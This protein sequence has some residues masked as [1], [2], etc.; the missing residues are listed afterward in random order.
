MTYNTICNTY[1]LNTLLAAFLLPALLAAQAQQPAQI[2]LPQGGLA[3]IRFDKTT[4]YLGIPYAAPPLNQLRWRAPQAP[5]RWAGLRPAQDFG[6]ACPQEAYEG[7]SLEEMSEDC[8]TLNVWHPNS[9]LAKL[10][11]F[12][13]VHGGALVRGGA[14]VPVYDGQHLASEGAVVVTINYR[15]HH[16]GFFAHPE[17][18]AE[19]AARGESSSNFGLLD[20]Q[21]ALRWVKENASRFGGDPGRITLAGE[22][23]G[24]IA[25][26]TLSI[27]PSSRG[28]YH[29]LIV[30]SGLSRMSLVSFDSPMG[31]YPS[32]FERSRITLSQFPQID[33]RQPMQALRAIPWKDLFEKLKG[34]N[35]LAGVAPIRDGKDLSMGLAEAYAAGR[36]LPVPL[37]IGAN[38]FEGLF[39]RRLLK[40]KTADVLELA[41]EYLNT[42]KAMYR[43][44]GRTTNELL[45]DAIWGDSNIV[46]AGRF[47]ARA[48]AA[49]HQPA[50]HYS[51]NYVPEAWRSILP[52]A[53]HGV[54]V[55]YLFGTFDKVKN[56]LNLP[57]PPQTIQASKQMRAYWI[58]FAN[59]ANPNQTGLPEWE[60]FTPGTEATLVIENSGIRS[61]PGHD[62][63]RLD[64]FERLS[65]Q[66]GGPI[67][68]FH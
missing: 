27:M 14:R 41:G 62:K 20:I 51:F 1:A 18:V 25:V 55:V 26:Q 49:I 4:R 50:Y 53:P 36:Q 2:T 33:P 10:P 45:A 9:A 37:M 68:R 30:Q 22:S 43:T 19:A 13:W 48:H 32:A 3:G 54:D 8:L 35:G 57:V 56:P 59:A 12:V 39:L 61:K 64:I 34:I 67:W 24:A 11:V 6:P 38:G 46:E 23:G 52:S 60:R 31:P 7:I 28:L 65:Q 16:L 21:A 40:V 58:Q 66:Q 5:P 47:T 15:L 44:Q 42:L 29:R 17:L 63:A